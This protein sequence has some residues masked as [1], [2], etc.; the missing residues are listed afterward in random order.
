MNIAVTSKEMILEASKRILM[1]QGWEAVN[2]RSV[3]SACGVAVG[4]IYNYFGSKSELTAEVVKS[5]WQEIFHT[6]GQE[7]RLNGFLDCIDW[8]LTCMEKGN[9]KYPGIFTLH[10]MSFP[11]EDKARGQLMM[12]QSW[13]HIQQ[14][15]YTVL[16]NDN[17]VRGDAFNEEFTRERFIELV[18]A[19]MV[20]ALLKGEYDGFLIKEV[21]RRSI[22]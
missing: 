14:N 4:S 19:L 8:F 3:A 11:G 16:V 2:I 13:Q 10:A 21:V 22:Y 5:V 1:E 17:A 15:L 7:Y 6:S 9:R 18:F 12:R 20:S